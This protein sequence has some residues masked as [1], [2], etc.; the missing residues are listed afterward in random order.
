[1]TSKKRLKP[2]DPAMH[3]DNEN[4]IREYLELAR[5]DPDPQVYQQA[6]KNVAKAE[7]AACLNAPAVGRELEG[8]PSKD[9][10]KPYNITKL[11]NHLV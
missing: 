2:F 10:G 8:W 9:S 11:N 3:L 4:V 1:M 6:L 5:N 7:E